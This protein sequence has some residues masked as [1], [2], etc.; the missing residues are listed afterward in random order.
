MVSSGRCESITS[1]LTHKDQGGC[2]YSVHHLLFTSSPNFSHALKYLLF[3]PN[4]SYY[5]D[6]Y[7]RLDRDNC[8][9][10]TNK[11]SSQIFV[12]RGVAGFY[13]TRASRRASL[14]DTRSPDQ[15][16]GTMAVAT[17]MPI[18]NRGIRA[19]PGQPNQVEAARGA[20]Y[21]RHDADTEGMFAKS[22][23]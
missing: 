7:Q 21:I 4:A 16:L 17:R 20:G 13:S 11:T 22:K 12:S 5:L 6:T 23:R 9:K 15:S 2:E 10:H 8:T 19:P 3:F 14:N 1:K 18:D